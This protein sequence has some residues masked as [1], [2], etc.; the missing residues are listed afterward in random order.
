MNIPLNKQKTKMIIHNKR[1]TG[2]IHAVSSCDET[3]WPKSEDMNDLMKNID[4][5]F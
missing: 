4:K 5:I 2:L 1:W 3:S